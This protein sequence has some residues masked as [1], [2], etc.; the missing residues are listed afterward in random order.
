M[1][2]LFKCHNM[3]GTAELKHTQCLCRFPDKHCVLLLQ[4]YKL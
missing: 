3:F 4:M 1:I 2:D